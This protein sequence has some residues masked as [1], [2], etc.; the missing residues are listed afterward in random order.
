MPSNR[1]PFLGAAAEDLKITATG[2]VTMR[3]CEAESATGFGGDEMAAV[4]MNSEV[5]SHSNAFELL[6]DKKCEERTL[7]IGDSIAVK[8]ADSKQSKLAISKCTKI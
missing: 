7:L 8:N 2:K 1:T 4:R 3:N 5:V 6:K